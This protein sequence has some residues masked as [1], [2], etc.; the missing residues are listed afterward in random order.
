MRYLLSLLFLLSGCADEL[1][2]VEDDEELRPKSLG[3]NYEAFVKG[4]EKPYFYQV[5]LKW[6]KFKGTLRISESSKIL[7]IVDAEKGSFLHHEISHDYRASYLLERIT[8]DGRIL[9]SESVYVDIPKDLVLS[10]A[11]KLEKATTLEAHR[12][13]LKPDSVITTFNKDLHISIHEIISEGALIQNYPDDSEN[14]VRESH[15]RDGGRVHIQ[16]VKS[17][18]S[19]R[20]LLNGESGGDG[21]N[22]AI[23]TGR[24]PGCA[25]TSGGRGGSAGSL[26][27][28][29]LQAFDMNITYENKGGK[30]GAAG[31]RGVAMS[32]SPLE[33]VHPPCHRDIPNGIDGALGAKGRFCLKAPPTEKFICSE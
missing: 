13:F 31:R 4:L 10:G 24:H 14:V 21:R 6:K 19:L 12:L 1:A 17:S 25:G 18:G 9:S 11:L 20:V 7:A 15:G 5:E 8:K 29:V 27:V 33:V 28:E 30:G 22:G 16:A 3:S 26:S 2:K 23:T 32:G